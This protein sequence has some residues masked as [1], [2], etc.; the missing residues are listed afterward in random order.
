MKKNKLDKIYELLIYD[1]LLLLPIWF[2][3]IFI[4]INGIFYGF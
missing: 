2:I 1:V 4:I 3:V